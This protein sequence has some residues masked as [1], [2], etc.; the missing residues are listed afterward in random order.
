MSGLGENKELKLTKY[1]K[2]KESD[3]ENNDDYDDETKK[4]IDELNKKK[5]NINYQIYD[6]LPMDNQ[7]EDN[8][9]NI[10]S[11]FG[12]NNKG[13]EE[14]EYD[15]GFIDSNDICKKDS[16]K[17]IVNSKFDDNI[18][19]EEKNNLDDIQTSEKELSND[20]VNIFLSQ[21]QNI[22]KEQNKNNKFNANYFP[23]ENK[24]E[25][26]EQNK[27]DEQMLINSSNI[28][29][30]IHNINKNNFFQ[31]ENNTSM[32]GNNYNDNNLSKNNES[33]EKI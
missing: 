6:S 8:N 33:N 12:I 30:D 22:S 14:E 3:V 2:L 10:D 20:N 15:E 7:Y 4:K 18:I 13:E 27:K 24:E 28:N 29:N 1:N 25:E 16:K 5:N 23:K 26:Y 17:S 21:D 9:K 32:Q 19:K 11:N 31:Y